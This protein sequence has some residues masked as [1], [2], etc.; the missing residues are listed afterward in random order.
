MEIGINVNGLFQVKMV[1]VIKAAIKEIKHT[2]KVI[3]ELK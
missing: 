3:S 2:V 1:I